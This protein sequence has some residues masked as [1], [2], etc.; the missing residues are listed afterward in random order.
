VPPPP[1]ITRAQWG[2][3]ETIGSRERSFAAIRKVII[4]HTAIDEADPVKQIQGIH[5]FH[6]NGRGWDDI[7]YNFLIDRAG[8]PA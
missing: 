5:R 4:H 1:I 8:T 6:V 3:D 7:G 2:A